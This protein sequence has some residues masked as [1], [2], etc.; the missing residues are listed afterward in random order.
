MTTPERKPGMPI[1]DLKYG[2]GF[3]E[4]MKELTTSKKYWKPRAKPSTPTT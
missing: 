1:T 2:S 4:K 3:N